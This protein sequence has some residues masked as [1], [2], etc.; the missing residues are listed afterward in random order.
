M[1][2]KDLV[3]NKLISRKVRILSRSTTDPKQ[4]PLAPQGIP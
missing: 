1:G 4:L 3:N 2:L